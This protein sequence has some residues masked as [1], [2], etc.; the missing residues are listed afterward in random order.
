MHAEAELIEKLRKIEALFARPGTE[1]ERVAAGNARERIRERLRQLERLE[2]PEEY[3]FSH[4]DPWSHRL[5]VAL[6]RRYDLRPYRY[7]GQRRTTV[8][9]KVTRTFLEQ[10][11]WPEFRQVNDVLHQYLHDVTQRVIAS[12]IS[13]DVADLEVREGSGEPGLLG[14]EA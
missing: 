7:R 10:T 8:M 3:R 13:G 6:L 4:P 5:F 1:G 14:S 9:V 11:L 2:S 12:A